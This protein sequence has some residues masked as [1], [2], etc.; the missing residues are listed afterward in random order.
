MIK[1]LNLSMRPFF[2]LLSLFLRNIMAL[3]L[4]YQGYRLLWK[5][6]NL[7]R[8]KNFSEIKT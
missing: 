3:L 4:R 7:T 5:A 8:V 2:C 1:Y 6:K